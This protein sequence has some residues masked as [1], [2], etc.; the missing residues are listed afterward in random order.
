MVRPRKYMSQAVF[1]RLLESYIAPM[2]FNTVIPHKD[3]EPLLHPSFEAMFKAIAGASRASKID[4]YTNGLML[5]KDMVKVFASVPNKVWLLITFHQVNRDGSRND[6]S[7]LEYMLVD[8]LPGLS[9][10]NVEII[11]VTHP[12]DQIEYER[13]KEWQAKWLNRKR[14]EKALIDVHV[15]RQINPWTGLIEHP[16]CVSF[17]G[18]PYADGNHFFVG[19][20]GNVI[21]CCMDLEE[22]IVLGNIMKN[23]PD[24]IC[25]ARDKFYGDMINGIVRRKLCKR[26]LTKSTTKTTTSAA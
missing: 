15:N 4:I 22:E 9:G 21:P 16:N 13:A 18:C 11:L 14:S 20:T 8:V 23:D 5:T 24:E 2:Q 3:G 17:E 26:C 12:L 1:D 25:E 19:V 7:A 10:L 6:Y